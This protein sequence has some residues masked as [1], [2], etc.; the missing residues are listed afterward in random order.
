MLCLFLIWD[1]QVNGAEVDRAERPGV[2]MRARAVFGL[3][4]AQRP[5]EAGSIRGRYLRRFERPR[6]NQGVTLSF[7]FTTATADIYNP[8]SVYIISNAN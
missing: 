2:C 4:I 6:S 3:L 5:T 1:R 8:C 7:S